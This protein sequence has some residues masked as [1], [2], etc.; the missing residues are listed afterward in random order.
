MNNSKKAGETIALS[1]ET[2]YNDRENASPL[3][4]LF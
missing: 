4:Y 1:P 2:G 3:L